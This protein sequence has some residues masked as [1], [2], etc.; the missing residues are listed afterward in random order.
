M[1]HLA[2][3]VVGEQISVEHLM[4]HQVLTDGTSDG[5]SYPPFLFGYD[6]GSERHLHAEHIFCG[7]RSEEHLDGDVIGDISYYAAY[8][9]GCD[10]IHRE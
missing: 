1:P 9:R 5:F 7:V 3:H 6:T 4:V 10:V 8:K 2:C